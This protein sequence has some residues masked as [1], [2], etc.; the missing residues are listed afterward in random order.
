MV[1]GQRHWAAIV[2]INASTEPAQTLTIIAKLGD[3]ASVSVPVPPLPPLSLHKVPMQLPGL[4]TEADK[5]PLTLQL[6]DR[7]DVLS[8]VSTE[9]AVRAA[10]ARRMVTFE[11]RIDGSVQY[12]ALNPARGSGDEPRALVLSLH[13]ASVEATNQAGSYADKSWAHLVA[14]TNRRPFGFDWEDWGRKDALEVLTDATARLNVDPARV[15]LTGHSMGGHGTWHLGV[16][17]PDRFAAIGPSAGWTSFYSYGGGRRDAEPTPMQAMLARA[18]LPS[19]TLRLKRN[20]L[21]HGVYILHGDADKTVGVA[22]ARTMKKALAELGQNVG[23]HEQPGAG[24]WWDDG[25]AHGV[26][27]VD[28]GPMF[29]YFARHRRPH[30]AEI[31]HVEFH[32]ASPGVSAWCRWAGVLDQQQPFE[33]SKID[34]RLDPLRRHVVGTTENVSRL[35]LD[36]GFLPPSKPI[37][38]EL[39]G[40]S[41]PD[42]PWPARGLVW[43]ERGE[44]WKLGK[45]PPP[46]LKGP[47]RYG[48]FKEAFDHRAVFVYGTRGTP[49]ENAW[50]L[51][52][53]R[54]DAE[55]FYY[56]GNGAFEVVADLVFSPVPPHRNVVVYGN[57][58]TNAAW[59]TLLGDSPVQVKRGEVRFGERTLRGDDLSC[60]FI[61]PRPGTADA[62]VG[63][64]AGT[65]APG[66][67]LT[68]RLPYF[69]SGIAYPD[70]IV[71][72]PRVL[73]ELANGV[74]IAGFFGSDWSIER[75]DFVFSK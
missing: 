38:F 13:G 70:C 20:Y 19:D 50:S 58:D 63:V 31:R 52:K 33:P 12:Y 54:Y 14:P 48:P 28:F 11:S 15:Y 59:Q 75:G 37:N 34:L 64:V 74:E 2:A 57:A 68:D 10:D 27:C 45:R 30:N 41:I 35:A 22:Q 46:D 5:V 62:S 43:L 40:V 44:T 21:Q 8:E 49:E 55:T 17:Y 36:L 69:V 53:A 73:A 9:L 72:R 32:T 18:A 7:G 16:T 24:H 3:A 60:V 4:E 42:A 6:A 47:H 56:R 39:D 67:R 65:G 66:Q 29:D 23:Y 1:S 26:G 25:D 71:L 61:R 51:A